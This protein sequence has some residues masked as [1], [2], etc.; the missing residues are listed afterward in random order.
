MA[1]ILAA[2]LGE[3]VDKKLHLNAQQRCCVPG[4]AQHNQENEGFAWACLRNIQNSQVPRTADHQ[5]YISN[6]LPWPSYPAFKC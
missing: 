5:A 4:L 1:A 6:K 3:K 2:I